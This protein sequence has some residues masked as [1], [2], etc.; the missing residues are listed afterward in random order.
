LTA[1]TG[2]VDL[3]EVVAA[4]KHDLGKYVA[5]RS[6][7][8]EFE[9]EL[10]DERVEALQADVLRTRTTRTGEVL[11]AWEVWDAAQAR[12]PEPLEPELGRVRDAVES[13]RGMAS[14]L[15]RGDAVELQPLVSSILAAQAEIRAELRSLHRRLA[16]G[17]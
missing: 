11:T 8:L 5:W 12:L 7:N 15:R 14:E 9:G 2:E 4:L 13:L 1:V 16:R 17:G 10:D 6:T 3:R